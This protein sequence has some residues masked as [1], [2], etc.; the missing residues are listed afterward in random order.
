MTFTP[1]IP[2]SGQSLGNSRLQVLNNFAI[3][4]STIAT[5][6]VDVNASGNGKHKFVHLPVQ[7]SPVPPPTTA[8]LEGALYTK[9]VGSGV[10]QLFYRR[11]SNGAEIQIT[12]G[13]GL[14]EVSVSG[15]AIFAGA[16]T[17]TLIDLSTLPNFYGFVTAY[18]GANLVQVRN[19]ATIMVLGGTYQLGY[20]LRAPNALPDQTNFGTNIGTLLISGSNL[21]LAITGFGA[22]AFPATVN[23]K[24]TQFLI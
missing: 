12:N 20:L 4:R 16:G 10:T 5:D 14:N 22:P 3:L 19:F 2:A 21:Q 11:E 15:T 6:H 24:I 7:T 17:Q 18:V 13:T 8:A 1:N 9:D 23:W